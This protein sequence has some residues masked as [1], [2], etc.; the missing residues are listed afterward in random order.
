MYNGQTEFSLERM[1]G[2]QTASSKILDEGIT[3]SKLS[4]TI[5]MCGPYGANYDG[6]KITLYSVYSRELVRECDSLKWDHGSI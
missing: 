2:M 4:L 1:G 3:S 5:Y 6:D